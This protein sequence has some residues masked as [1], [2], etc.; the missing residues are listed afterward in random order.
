MAPKDDKQE[1][2]PT[3]EKKRRGHPFLLGLLLGLLAGVALGWWFRPPES[4]PLEDLKR[5]TETN[6]EQASS[7]SREKLADWVESMA[8]SLRQK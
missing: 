3:P 2:Q 7:E 5:A 1:T 6:L 4:F 8:D